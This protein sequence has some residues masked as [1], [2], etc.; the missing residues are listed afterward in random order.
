M[1]SM[2]AFSLGMDEWMVSSDEES[3]ALHL[4][5]ELEV[6]MQIDDTAASSSPTNQR[7]LRVAVSPLH[8][9]QS[10]EG[11][12]PSPPSSPIIGG[13]R[14]PDLVASTSPVPPEPS[15]TCSIPGSS[16]GLQQLKNQVS[17][18]GVRP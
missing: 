7:K 11:V 2:K 6:N 10:Q 9:A 1:E 16:T 12:S 4:D 8:V 18:C 14:T 3:E 17:T 13:R 15:R 5:A